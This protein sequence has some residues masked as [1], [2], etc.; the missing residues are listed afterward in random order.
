M[1]KS[2]ADLQ[3]GRAGKEIEAKTRNELTQ[4]GRKVKELKSEKTKKE[5]ASGASGSTSKFGYVELDPA[6]SDLL[7]GAKIL[8]RTQV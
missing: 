5:V 7:G 6:L 3:D 8:Q 2:I 4:S 1:M